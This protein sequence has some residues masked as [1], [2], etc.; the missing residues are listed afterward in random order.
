MA[1]PR[2]KASSFSPQKVTQSSE[3]ETAQRPTASASNS[4]PKKAG[5]SGSQAETRSAPSQEE[6]S[7]VA[8]EIYLQ[9]GAADGDALADWLQAEKELREAFETG[10]PA[11]S[12]RKSR[13]KGA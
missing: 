6:I 2:D 13:A 8:Y 11:G 10:N 4:L 7:V 3:P 1:A 9:R 12:E 5:I